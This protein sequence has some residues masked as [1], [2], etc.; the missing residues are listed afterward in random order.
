MLTRLSEMQ[1]EAG[2]LGVTIV[3]ARFMSLIGYKTP[4]SIRPAEYAIRPGLDVKPGGD[5]E[6]VKR[7]KR[8][9]RAATGKR[10]WKSPRPRRIK[11]RKP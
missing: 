2:R 5:G 7:A 4:K 9:K 10:R 11:T 3:P 1:N 6:R 8:V